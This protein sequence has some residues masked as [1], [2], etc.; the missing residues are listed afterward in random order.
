MQREGAC[1][2]FSGL[3]YDDGRSFQELA[4]RWEKPKGRR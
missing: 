4:K 2:S 1:Q 3:N